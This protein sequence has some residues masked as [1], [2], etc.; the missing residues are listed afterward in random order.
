MGAGILVLALISA[1]L[2]SK[3]LSSRIAACWVGFSFVVLCVLGWG[4][5]ENGLILYA[6]YF[7]WAFAMLLYQLVQWIGEKTK[8]AFLVPA[9]SAVGAV[10]LL[11]NNI[12]EMA[13]L[14]KFAVTYYVR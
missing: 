12:P 13:A 11:L 7:G 3:K 6:L 14:L 4:T 10:W 9:L 2:N 1:V 5:Q 8:A